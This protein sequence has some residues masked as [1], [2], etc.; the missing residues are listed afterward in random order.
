MNYSEKVEWLRRYRA[1]LKK[2]KLLQDELTV[3]RNRAE[4]GGKTVDGVP[5]G[6]SDGQSLPRAVES[7]QRAEMELKCQQNVCGA[8]RHEVVAAIGTVPDDQDQAILR[9]RYLRGMQWGKIAA[10]L[11]M[12]ERWVRRRARR[13]VERMTIE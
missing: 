8:I 1:A 4:G 5:G 7:I 3:V 2:E 6:T 9:W 10:L 13:A 11:P 12:D